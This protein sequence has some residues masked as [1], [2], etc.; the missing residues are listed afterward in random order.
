MSIENNT[1]LVRIIEFRLSENEEIT[2]KQPQAN[3]I[4]EHKPDFLSPRSVLPIDEIDHIGHTQP[5]AQGVHEKGGNEMTRSNEEKRR[6]DAKDVGVGK[7]KE[8]TENDGHRWHSIVLF[9]MIAF[10][11]LE[12]VMKMRQTE[13]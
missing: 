2:W 12:H 7:L 6:V 1:T 10:K 3:Q 9:M 5:I 13:E 4:A 11:M 8:M